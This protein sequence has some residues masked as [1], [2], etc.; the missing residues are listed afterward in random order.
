MLIYTK[1]INDINIEDICN[2]IS[3]KQIESRFL[4]FKQQKSNGEEDKILKTVCGFANAD[5]GL[6]IYG[7]KE[8]NGEAHEI[9]G[10]SLNGKSWDDKKLQIQD[11]IYG[12]IEPHLNIEINMITSAD[13]KLLILIKVPKSWN[14]PHCV[15]DNQK[16]IFYLRRDGRT[17][18][19]EYEELKRMFD[20]N[21]SLIEKI[22][23]FRDNRIAKLESENRNH[24]K[25][26]FHAVPLNAYS[27]NNIN[28]EKA[29]NELNG[30][31]IGR[32]YKYNFE[33]LYH[34]NNEENLEF[35]RNGT[36]ERC[37]TMPY[38][39]EK[40]YLDTYEKDC[41]TFCKEILQLYKELDIICPVVFFVSLVNIQGYSFMSNGVKKS[42]ESIPDKREKLDPNGI[43]INNEN[44]IEEKVKDLF[45]PLWNHYGFPENNTPK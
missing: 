20:L 23:N 44:E 31:I 4:E 19:M 8:K 43:I 26:I 40:M 28:L 3:E 30:R 10:V 41:I 16:R 11:W 38:T 7:L 17:D 45:K 13:D 2:L 14:P 18:P 6:F 15:I 39:N 33:G 27:N 5:G 21:N 12:R 42:Y 34:N 32:D 22:N 37:Y 24:Y 1:N 36:F 9:T 35:F 29:K 25:V